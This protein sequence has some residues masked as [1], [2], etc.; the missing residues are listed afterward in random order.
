M[1]GLALGSLAFRNF[2]IFEPESVGRPVFAE[3]INGSD[4][5]L[6]LVNASDFFRKHP[7]NFADL[8]ENLDH[9]EWFKFNTAMIFVFKDMV[10]DYKIKYP[11]TLDD[12]KNNVARP[13]IMLGSYFRQR[14]TNLGLYQNIKDLSDALNPGGKKLTFDD[15]LSSLDDNTYR[16]PGRPLE[17]VP[18][19]ILLSGMNLPISPKDISGVRTDS[20]GGLLK[21]EARESLKFRDLYSDK[22]SGLLFVR[23]RK[24]EDV[25]VGD[26]FIRYGGNNNHIGTVIGKKTVNGETYL[27]KAESNVNLDGRISVSEVN[28]YNFA[29]TF[30]DSVK[31]PAVVSRNTKVQEFLNS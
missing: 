22:V 6:A 31:L 1:S 17:C 2:P 15:A 13:K 4:K 8:K 30:G 25:E 16:R 23:V 20:A 28:A 3:E 5:G 27:L 19:A 9:G 24:I 10:E 21:D 7:N 12:F 18:A 14:L 29:D 26:C 11:Y